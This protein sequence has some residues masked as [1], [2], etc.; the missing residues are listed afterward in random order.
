VITYADRRY[1]DGTF[2]EKIGFEKIQTSKPNYFIIANGKLQSRLNWQKHLLIK[3]L[4]N[5]YDKNLTEWENIQLSGYDRIW[6][7][8]NYVFGWK[9]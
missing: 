9:K 7:C 2:Y 1:S 4:K 3:K 6:D 8:G 5:N